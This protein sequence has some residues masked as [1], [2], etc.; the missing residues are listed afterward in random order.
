MFLNRPACFSPKAMIGAM[1]NVSVIEMESRSQL[2]E[3]VAQVINADDLFV[4]CDDAVFSGS[5]IRS[6]L[7]EMVVTGELRLETLP[8]KFRSPGF[9]A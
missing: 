7:L 1:P 2:S 5:Q 8:S 6:R 4:R 9:A 3:H